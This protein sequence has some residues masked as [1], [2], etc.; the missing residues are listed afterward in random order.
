MSYKLLSC[1]SVALFLFFT[2]A[3]AQNGTDPGCRV[4]ISRKLWHD[5]VDKAQ[6]AVLKAGFAKGDNDDVVHF[7]NN[8]LVRQVDA[9]QCKIDKDS[10]GDQR[11]VAYLRG[12]ERML[13]SVLTEY[14]AHRFVPSNFP[15]LIGAYDDAIQ[16]DKKIISIEPVIVKQEY[17]VSKMLIGSDAFAGNPGL[18]NIKSW[19]VLKFAEIYPDKVF[20]TLKDNPNIPFRDS[21]IKVVGYKYPRQLYDYAAAD[22][23]L[24]FAISTLR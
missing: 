15:V 7:V 4:P 12:L 22:N 6:A 13:R 21:L 19:L 14:R 10:I 23:K 24:G 18:S 1:C 16:L 8:A 9:L 3:S 20:I 11:K 5:N 2:P 17:E